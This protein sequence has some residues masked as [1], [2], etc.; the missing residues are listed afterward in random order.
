MLFKNKC[1]VEL[2]AYFLN[3]YSC[4]INAVSY[5]VSSGT[6]IIDRS[7]FTP[8][9]VFSIAVIIFPVIGVLF[10]MPEENIYLP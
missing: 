1:Y 5:I 3:K 9:H 8:C 2:L 6:V 4:E 7:M 10:K